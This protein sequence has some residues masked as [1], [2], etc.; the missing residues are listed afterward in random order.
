M[1]VLVDTPV[2]SAALRR[3]DASS[4]HFKSE[5][6]KL[7][8][9]GLVELIGPIRQELLSGIR[10]QKQFNLVRDKLRRFVDLPITVEDYEE[11]ASYY[12]RC[13][14][15]GIQGSSTDFLI[16]A[17]A[18]RHD[19]KIFTDDRDFNSYSKVLPVRLYTI[20]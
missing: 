20:T 17:I 12:N 4:S 9:Q 13:R 2:W 18:N 11:A 14:A 7:V 15:K 6:T 1:R 10:D 5:M 19:L 3:P 16:C 8:S